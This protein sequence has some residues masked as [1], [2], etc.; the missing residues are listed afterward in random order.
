[1]PLGVIG[2]IAPWNYPLHNFFNPVLAALFSGNAIVVKPSEYTLYSSLHFARIVRRVLS[3]C[4]H[5]PQLVQLLL[6]EAHVGQ[7]LVDAPIDKLFFTG[8]TVVGHM[9]AQRAAKRLLPVCLELGGKDAFV[10]CDDADVK[11]AATICMRGVFQ[12]SGQNCIGIERV[13]VH[14]A[15]MDKFLQIAL[16]TVKSMRVGTDVGAMTMGEKAQSKIEQ[17][18][19]DAVQKGAKLLTGGKRATV[20]G[21]GTFFEPTVL[22]DV[23]ATMDIANEEVFGPV[24]TI[25]SWKNDEQLVRMINDCQF[26][27]GSSV[28]SASTNRAHSIIS[29]L[30]VGMSNVNDFATNYLCQSMP[31]G[32]TKQSGSDRFAGIE[33]LRGCCIMKAVTHDRFPGIKTMIPKAF[34][35]PTGFNA[36]ELAAEINDLVYGRGLMTKVD[37]L[38]HLIGMVMFPSWRPRAVGSG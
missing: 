14:E 35:Y 10:I 25:M 32:G 27:L 29:K 33:G 13:F 9:V 19:D 20:N 3:L 18:V 36:F 26:G 30:R 38:R 21:A 1:M 2:A 34:K 23:T 16:P 6:G 28:F 22:K 4:G 12:N 8:S 15:V 5:S 11:H 7:A 37:N 17:L 24:M 31:F